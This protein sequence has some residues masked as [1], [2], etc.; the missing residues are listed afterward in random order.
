MQ[1]MR[2]NNGSL[3]LE[4]RKRMAVATFDL[5]SGYDR[6]ITEYLSRS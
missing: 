2:D 6:M 5:T 1:Q 3:S 4:F